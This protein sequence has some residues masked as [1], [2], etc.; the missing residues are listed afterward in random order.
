MDDGRNQLFREYFRLLRGLR[1]QSEGMAIFVLAEA[2]TE[3]SITRLEE[4]GP[5]DVIT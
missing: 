3:A 1:Q 5:P 4:P 2:L